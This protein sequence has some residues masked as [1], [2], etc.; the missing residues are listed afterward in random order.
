MMGFFSKIFAS[1]NAAQ[2]VAANDAEA[3]R[4]AQIKKIEALLDSVNSASQHVR[5]YYITFL[6]ACFYIA[7]IV[8]STTDLMLLKNTPVTMPLLNVELPIT[9]FYTFAPYFFLLLHFN[10]LLQFS[11][12]ADKTHR[13]DQAVN[14]LQD[15]DSRRYYYT[16][17]FAFAFTQILS[18]RHHSG[19]LRFLLTLMVWITAIWLPLGILI[20]LQ[21]G[22]LPYH[23]EEILF[24]Q[25]VAVTLDLLVLLI[26]W[27]VIRAPDSRWRSW[28]KQASGLSWLLKIIRSVANRLAKR[29]VIQHSLL[30]QSEIYTIRANSHPLLEGNIGVLTGFVVIVFVWGVAVLPDSQQE[31]WMADVVS[32]RWLTEK[33]LST[34]NREGKPYFLL[35]EYLF[36]RKWM[37]DEQGKR[38]AIA[39]TFHRNLVI[40]EQL[41]IANTLKAEEEVDLVSKDEVTRAA[42]LK[43]VTGLVLSGR[44]LRYADFIKSR[45]PKVDFV[46]AS[47]KPSD[48]RY[49]SF[50][51]AMLVNAM[52]T[53]TKLQ[54]ANLS[55]AEL[56]EANLQRAHLQRANLQGADLQNASV[57]LAHLQRAKMQYAKLQGANFFLAKLEKASFEHAKLQG[58]NFQQASLQ[59]ARLGFAKRLTREDLESSIEI[60]QNFGLS[61]EIN[62]KSLVVNFVGNYLNAFW[63]HKVESFSIVPIWLQEKDWIRIRTHGLDLDFIASKVTEQMGTQIQSASFKHANLQGADLGFAQLQGADLSYAQLQGTDLR[64]AR[65]QGAS[66]RHAK[67]QRA[68]FGIT[69]ISYSDITYVDFD[70]LTQD[71]SKKIRALEMQNKQLELELDQINSDEFQNEKDRN[72]ILSKHAKNQEVIAPMIGKDIWDN[73]RNQQ[74]EYSFFSDR[75]GV[76]TDQSDFQNKLVT[77]LLELACKD[78][79]AVTGIVKYRIADNKLEFKGSVFPANQLAKCLLKLTNKKNQTDQLICPAMS[80]IDNHTFEILQRIASKKNTD[81]TIQPTFVCRTAQSD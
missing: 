52:M 60:A 7:L 27:P 2:D 12:L 14:E 57:Q 17:L 18:A 68:R 66:L 33:P 20:G 8:W 30:Q 51:S 36:D 80:E 75:L 79:W 50:K 44:D 11:L 72:K 31:Q 37:K 15:E 28:I 1:A 74:E 62:D 77:S 63:G 46:G 67:L 4:Q 81:S 56:Q 76:V 73:E 58:A 45:L 40:R 5:N 34:S 25:R 23:D 47:F 9:G 35:T 22:F 53:K 39:S 64:Y 13:F 42:A 48:L 69:D 32:A 55:R 61:N 21:V 24:W 29:T 16:R 26:F 49:A 59:G 78:R 19:L 70:F 10:L 65:L 54:G 6:L 43:K 3:A 71:E 38:K 41:L